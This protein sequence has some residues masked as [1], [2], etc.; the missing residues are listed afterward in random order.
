MHADMVII[1]ILLGAIILGVLLGLI[2]R[3]KSSIEVKKENAHL[4]YLK[5]SRKTHATSYSI[6]IL[7]SR[8]DCEGMVVS[9]DSSRLH[10]RFFDFSA[11]GTKWNVKKALDYWSV[12][13][14]YS[15]SIEN[16]AKAYQSYDRGPLFTIPAIQDLQVLGEHLNQFYN[17]RDEQRY[18]IHRGFPDVHFE[19]LGVARKIVSRTL[20]EDAKSVYAYDMYTKQVLTLPISD[21]YMKYDDEDI[22]CGVI[23]IG[24]F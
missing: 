4:E 8:G 6:G 10:G 21:D 9:V 5:D 11:K 12:S 7:Y 13:Y 19:N 14:G 17:L 2:G 23:L 15:R 3:A 18:G 20:T 16:N 24:F 1:V 22:T